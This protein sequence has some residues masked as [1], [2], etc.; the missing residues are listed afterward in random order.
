MNIGRRIGAYMYRQLVQAKFHDNEIVSLSTGAWSRTGR[1]W[2]QNS[3]V[4]KV[5][6]LAAALLVTVCCTAAGV[7]AIWSFFVAETTVVG[8][9]LSALG[10]L[11]L[12]YLGLWHL[13]T[14]RWMAARLRGKA[15]VNKSK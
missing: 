3:T 13:A 4:G 11:F 2:R 7:A 12:L 10:I 14:A 9:V 8:R 15:K 6:H 5:A 1:E